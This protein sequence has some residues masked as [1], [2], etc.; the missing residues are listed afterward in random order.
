[1]IFK[2]L[3][4]G[5]TLGKVLFDEF[6][7]DWVWRIGFFIIL[8]FIGQ[9]LADVKLVT[10]NYSSGRVDEKAALLNALLP[11]LKMS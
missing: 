2:P 11:S 4:S 3:K 5:K 9:A 10:P 8:Y 6:L 7:M 1:M